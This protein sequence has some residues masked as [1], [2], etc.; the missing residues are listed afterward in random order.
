MNK[1]NAV[2]QPKSVVEREF[3]Q[4]ILKYTQ[5]LSPELP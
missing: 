5:V 3:S 2:T 1:T 4:M